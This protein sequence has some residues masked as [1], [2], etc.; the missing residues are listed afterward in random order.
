MDYYIVVEF[1]NT[2]IFKLESIEIYELILMG[3]LS[4]IPDFTFKKPLFCAILGNTLLSTV[5]GVSGAGST[6]DNTLLTPFWMQNSL[7]RVQLRVIR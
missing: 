5:P 7:F 2:D 4:E 1:F 6:P 3:F